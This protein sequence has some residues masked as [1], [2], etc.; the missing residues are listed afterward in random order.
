MQKAF[1]Q[2]IKQSVLELSLYY[3][4]KPVNLIKWGYQS[5]FNGISS[6]THIVFSSIFLKAPSSPI[7]KNQ[8]TLWLM[9]DT[10]KLIF[11]CLKQS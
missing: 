1:F 2:P 5:F 8:I 9:G 6:P 10:H 11:H 3:M 4:E 7:T